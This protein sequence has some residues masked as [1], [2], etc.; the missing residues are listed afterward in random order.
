MTA[1]C[2]PFLGIAVSRSSRLK[3]TSFLVRRCTLLPL[4]CFTASD[5]IKMLVGVSLVVWWFGLLQVAENMA[6]V[7]ALNLTIFRIGGAVASVLS[8]AIWTNALYPKLLEY[9]GD[10]KLAQAAY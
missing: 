9:M 2:A 4:A 5:L 1:V 3:L 6:T 10:A 8:G 7:T